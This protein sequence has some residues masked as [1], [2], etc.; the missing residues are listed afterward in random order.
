VDLPPD[1]ILEEHIVESGASVV[2]GISRGSTE[3]A[4][5]KA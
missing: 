4:S 3:G 5:T 2:T 1:E